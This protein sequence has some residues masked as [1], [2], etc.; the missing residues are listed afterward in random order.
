M[1]WKSPSS[2]P[3]IDDLRRSYDLEAE[4]A[5]KGYAGDLAVRKA[6][7]DEVEQSD[8]SLS[9]YVKN[10]KAEMNQAHDRFRERVAS[11]KRDFNAKLD[12][13]QAR[14]SRHY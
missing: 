6:S 1:G 4:K 5:L 14:R 11:A 7:L 2:G 10:A 3:S 8:P 13:A 12:E 9:A